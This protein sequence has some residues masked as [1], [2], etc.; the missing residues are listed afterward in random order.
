MALLIVLMLTWTLAA[1]ADHIAD[2]GTTGD[3]SGARTSPTI[4]AGLG[5]YTG[6]L[7][8]SDIDWYRMPAAAGGPSCVKLEAFGENNVT[9][10]LAVQGDDRVREI[11]GKIDPGETVVLGI[12]TPGLVAVEY[13]ATPSP[14][15]PASGSPARPGHYT[16][17]ATRVAAPASASNDGFLGM[18]AG[19]SL[20]GASPLQGACTGGKMSPLGGMMDTRDTYT[21]TLAEAT[22][23]T[24]SF[25]TSLN[26][27]VVGLQVL[28]SAGNA[29]GAPAYSGDMATV[30]LPAGTYY[31]QTSYASANLEDVTYVLG[32]VVGPDPPSNGCRPNC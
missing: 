30:S 17:A 29:I 31:M 2:P 18:D 13:G 26:D 1:G 7:G 15:D 16:F 8:P 23:V 10:T 11:A 21:F 4:L 3:A 6:Y 25:A 5:S 24:Y 19:G 14:N 9:Y 12:A 27:R 32:V 22:A 28:D 20:E